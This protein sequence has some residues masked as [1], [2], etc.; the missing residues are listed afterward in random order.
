MNHD[1]RV[2]RMRDVMQLTALRRST[3]YKKLHNDSTFPRPIP[4]SDS[5]SRGAPVGF[6][7]SEVLAWIES[8]VAKREGQ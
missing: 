2:I 8:R 7:Q 3:I 1:L 6:L 5:A 4:L